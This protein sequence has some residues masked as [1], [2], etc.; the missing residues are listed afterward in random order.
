MC[1]RTGRGRTCTT[2]TMRLTEPTGRRILVV[3]DDPTVGAALEYS[4]TNEGYEIGRARDGRGA[5]AAVADRTPDLILLDLNMPCMGGFEVCRR[6]KADPVT[7]LL[8]IV[9][10][11]GD[12][13]S[14]AR[15]Q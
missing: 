3:D 1:A 8:P 2:N 6:I 15:L 4:L 11:T 14:D 7:S 5:L 13:E 10:L 9:I 12:S